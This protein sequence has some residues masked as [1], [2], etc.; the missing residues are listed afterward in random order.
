MFLAVNFPVVLGITWGRRVFSDRFPIDDAAVPV[1]VTTL[2]KQTVALKAPIHFEHMTVIVG[3]WFGGLNHDDRVGPW[4][5]KLTPS[6]ALEPEPRCPAVFS[7]DCRSEQRLAY[8]L[9][10]KSS[11]GR[12]CCSSPLLVSHCKRLGIVGRYEQPQPPGNAW[13]TA[14]LDGTED[15]CLIHTEACSDL[16]WA[17]VV[18]I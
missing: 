2:H 9:D 7:A 18:L 11:W 13:Q 16:P 4:R 15:L 17:R 1:D 8:E 5:P 6:E 14:S 10:P 3:A 12:S